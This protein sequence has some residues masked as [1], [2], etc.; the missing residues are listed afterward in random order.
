M[1]NLPRRIVD[2]E[3]NAGMGIRTMVYV[4]GFNLYHGLRDLGGRKWLWLDLEAL[5]RRLCREND[6]L[7]GVK[8]FTADVRDDPAAQQRQATYLA[9][10]ASHTSVDV[11]KGRFQ[12]NNVR[13][14]SCN[15]HWRSYEEKETDVAIAATMIEDAVLHRWDRALL[16]SADADLCPAV[17]VVRHLRPEK[18]VIAA[19]PPRRHSDELGNACHGRFKV[20]ESKVRQSQLP[21]QVSKPDGTTLVRPAYWA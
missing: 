3:G 5:G 2:V 16:L 8:Y 6:D 15:R 1:L 11:H 13:C 18:T 14:F 12:Q 9:A 19:F 10:L 7:V 21:P 20:S 17:R 4:D